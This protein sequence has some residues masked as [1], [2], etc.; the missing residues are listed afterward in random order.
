[1]HLEKAHTKVSDCLT[2]NHSGCCSCAHPCHAC[3]P[4]LLFLACSF[5][6]AKQ[7]HTNVLRKH[8]TAQQVSAAGIDLLCKL[9]VLDPA[10]RLS[11]LDAFKVF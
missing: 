10:K 8:L 2:C 5:Y 7:G 4:S 11:A 3:L 6:M 1:M 9:L